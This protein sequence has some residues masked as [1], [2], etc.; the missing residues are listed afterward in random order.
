[1]LFTPIQNMI[2]KKVQTENE[3]K[4][5]PFFQKANF[6]KT[7][8][9]LSYEITDIV[10]GSV[11]TDIT[12]TYLKNGPNPMYEDKAAHWFDGD[13]MIHAFNFKNGRILYRN[14]QTETEKID[15]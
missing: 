12:G 4:C 9:E 15:F 2:K 11:P 1:M 14:K 13:G 8:K 10:F 6:L 7:D 5:I 3:K